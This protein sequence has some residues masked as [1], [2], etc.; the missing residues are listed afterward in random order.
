VSDTKPLWLTKSQLREVARLE[1]PKLADRKFNAL[2][3]ERMLKGAP[4]S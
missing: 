3:A 2:W 4:K 1:N